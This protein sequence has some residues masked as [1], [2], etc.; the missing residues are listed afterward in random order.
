MLDATCSV[1]ETAFAPQLKNKALRLS[2]FLH[3]ANLD[4]VMA[5]VALNMT[6]GSVEN[7][8]SRPVE[9]WAIAAVHACTNHCCP[10]GV[11]S[12]ALGPNV[13]PEFLSDGVGGLWHRCVADR[14]LVEGE[15]LTICYDT[16]ATAR[17]AGHGSLRGCLKQ[18][19][20]FDCRCST[21]MPAMP[22]G[23]A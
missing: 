14:D 15:E 17:E 12:A 7:G 20:H 4:I 21:C 1:L 2:S 10:P 13:H 3:R 11:A 6:Q 18:R 19:R 8:G 23:G 22:G 5:Q 16:A 9:I